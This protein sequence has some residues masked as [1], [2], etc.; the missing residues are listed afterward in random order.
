MEL[1]SDQ[2]DHE[3]V[4]VRVD[5]MAREPDV[6]REI[7]LAVRTADRAVLTEDGAMTGMY[8]VAAGGRR[9]AALQRLVAEGRLADLLGP[10]VLAAI[11]PCQGSE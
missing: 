11:K 6:V 7:L 4:V 1:A 9:L 10:E 5:A 8:A 2:A 3:V